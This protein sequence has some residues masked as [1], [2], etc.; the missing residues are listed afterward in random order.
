VGLGVEARKWLVGA[1]AV[2]GSVVIWLAYNQS[3][4]V[5]Y[6]IYM[7]YSVGGYFIPNYNSFS[8]YAKRVVYRAGLKYEK[9]V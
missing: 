8:S 9:Q 5:S 6:E 2:V 4:D 7:K 1:Q 3:A